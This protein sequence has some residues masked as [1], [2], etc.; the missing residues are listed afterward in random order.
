MAAENVMVS[1][2]AAA[3]AVSGSV[4]DVAL[5]PDTVAPAGVNVIAMPGTPTVYNGPLGQVVVLPQNSVTV[6]AES[7]TALV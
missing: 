6:P 5:G 4:P 1:P 2:S 7:R 3:V